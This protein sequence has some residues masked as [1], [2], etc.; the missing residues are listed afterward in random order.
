MQVRRRVARNHAPTRRAP[1]SESPARTT[2]TRSVECSPMLHRMQLCGSAARSAW[3]CRNQCGVQPGGPMP[4]FRNAAVLSRTVPSRSAASSGGRCQVHQQRRVRASRAMPELG[5]PAGQMGQVVGEQ[6][7]QVGADVDPARAHH[8]HPRPVRV[9]RA[10]ARSRYTAVPPR[11]ITK[12]LIRMPSTSPSRMPLSASSANSSRSRRL[13]AHSPAAASRPRSRPGSPGSAGAAAAAA[14]RGDGGGA[15]APATTGPAPSARPDAQAGPGPGAGAAPRAA[16]APRPAPRR[17]PPATGRR[18]S[19]R[20]AAPPASPATAP[21][22][23][24]TRACSTVRPLRSQDRNPATAGT[25]T[26][27]HRSASPRCSRNVH[28]CA[29]DGRIAAHRVRRPQVPVRL[30]PLLDRP[31]RR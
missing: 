7:L 17:P 23:G 26:S 15:P 11:P 25:P 22:A 31:D 21:S 10:R 24:A 6:P 9:V 12:S 20:P 27:C 14:G 16:A 30:Q 19:P 18:R 29:S 5:G 4:F 1:E 28:H 2:I 8:L 3:L 13:P